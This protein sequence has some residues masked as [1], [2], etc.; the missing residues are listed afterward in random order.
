MS[1]TVSITLVNATE[2]LKRDD[3]RAVDLADKNGC[4]LMKTGVCTV[5]IERCCHLKSGDDALASKE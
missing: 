4:F 5:L 3:L 1:A 2:L